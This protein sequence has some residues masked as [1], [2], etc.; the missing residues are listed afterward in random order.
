VRSQRSTFTLATYPNWRRGAPLAPP[1]AVPSPKYLQNLR[2]AP[3]PAG[4]VLAF[5]A[6]LPM[7]LTQVFVV[8]LVCG[9]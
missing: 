5:D 3:T 7:T 6:E 4:V 9:A 8:R 2:L 1:L